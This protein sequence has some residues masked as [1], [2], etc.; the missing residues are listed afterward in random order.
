VELTR[1]VLGLGEQTIEAAGDVDLIGRCTGQ[2]TN[3]GQT[4]Q[5]L[6]DTP[7]ETVC[8]HVGLGENGRSQS[9]LLFEQ[10]GEQ[11]LHVNLL[12]AVST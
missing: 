6:L 12:M 5:L 4:F 9:A 3:F 2:A 8:V 7:F 11:V 1:F 10:R